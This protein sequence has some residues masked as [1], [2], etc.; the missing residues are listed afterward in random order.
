MRLGCFSF[1]QNQQM[2]T[3]L[4][5]FCSDRSRTW[6][7]GGGWQCSHTCCPSPLPDGSQMLHHPPQIS[8]NPSSVFWVLAWESSGERKKLPGSQVHSEGASS[9][10]P[11][12]LKLRNYCSHHLNIMLIH[13]YV[14]LLL[15]FFRCDWLTGPTENKD[16]NTLADTLGG[17]EN[18]TLQTHIP[19]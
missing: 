7:G 13:E 4:C 9:L 19:S 15:S 17:K 2:K 14:S 10:W 1:S 5:V 16:K 8:A 12:E 11:Q 3:W 6:A 18:H